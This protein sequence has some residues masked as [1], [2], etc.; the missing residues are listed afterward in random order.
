MESRSWI[1]R[2]PSAFSRIKPTRIVEVN[3]GKNGESDYNG[4][5]TMWSQLRRFRFAM[6]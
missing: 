2:C 3:E 5:G 4:I 1:G 6:S